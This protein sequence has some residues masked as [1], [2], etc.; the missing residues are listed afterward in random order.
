[1][2]GKLELVALLESQNHEDW[3]GY[4]L[5]VC[6]LH[7]AASAVVEIDRPLL[8]VSQMGGPLAARGLVP[9]LKSILYY[10]NDSGSCTE[11]G[12]VE[13]SDAGLTRVA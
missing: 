4:I 9:F 8:V 13:E 1:L 11:A 3:S 7:L 10:G 6:L 12:R 2:F 5:T